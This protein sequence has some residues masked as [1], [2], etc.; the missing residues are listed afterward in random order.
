MDQPTQEFLN[1]PILA[2]IPA[3]PLIGALLNL[4]FGRW[5]S[6]Q[7][8]HTIA[9]AAVAAAFGIAAYSVFGP[10]YG[11]FRAGAGGIGLYHNV[12]TW[13][14]VG[15]F[16]AQLA[17]RLDTLSAV[18]ILIVTFVGTLIHIYSTGYMAHEPRR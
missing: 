18:M 17:F 6:K 13:I 16:K 10:L 9:I 5:F 3:L 14:Q 11:E 4:T 1:L 7:T 15:S 12:Y 2:W 8:V